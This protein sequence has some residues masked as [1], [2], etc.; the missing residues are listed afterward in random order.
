MRKR[1]VWKLCFTRVSGIIYVAHVRISATVWAMHTHWLFAGNVIAHLV[2]SMSG[3][4]SFG[5]AVYEA[6]KGKEFEGWAFFA[7]GAIC[8]IVAFDQAW[9]DEHRNAEILIAQRAAAEV[10]QNFWKDQS[11]QK[12]GSLRARDEL[13][14]QNYGVLAE[15]QSSLAALSNKLVDVVK[16]EPSRID[17]QWT[18]LGQERDKDNAVISRT[19]AFI[20]RTNK[21]IPEVR[22]KIKCPF[23]FE[24]RAAG[25]TQ[26]DLLTYTYSSGQDSNQE[27][28][29]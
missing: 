25:L 8:L 16:P 12:D 15:T 27:A 18:P 22:H 21:P 10:G 24:F 5:I 7:I 4:V 17:V 26:T 1:P 23:P 28:S 13:L 29:G 2:A 11:Y 20:A 14:T 19:I 9:Q 3:F 6:F